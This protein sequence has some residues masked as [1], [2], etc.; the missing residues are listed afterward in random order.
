VNDVTG[1]G[2]AILVHYDHTIWQAGPGAISLGGQIGTSFF[3]YN[4]VHQDV[5]YKYSWINMGFVFRREEFFSCGV[6]AHSLCGWILFLQRR[7]RSQC[8]VWL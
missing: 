4:Y 8:G 7:R 3:H 2:P 1:F 6:F 5:V